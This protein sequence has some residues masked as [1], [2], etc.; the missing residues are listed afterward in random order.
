MVTALAGR[1]TYLVAFALVVYEVA[2][3]LL[4]QKATLDVKVILEGL[5]LAALRAGIGRRS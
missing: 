1:K 2:G 3:Y 4:G 5:G